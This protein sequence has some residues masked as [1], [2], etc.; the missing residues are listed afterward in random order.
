LTTDTHVTS[1]TE[2]GGKEEKTARVERGQR[3]EKKN[4]R[5][6]RQ[7]QA[8]QVQVKVLALSRQ[9]AP[10]MQGLEAQGLLQTLSVGL[11]LG[12]THKNEPTES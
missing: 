5:Q 8:Y 4:N 11:P 2:Q 10:F 6:Q 3:N 1:Q 9:V 7:T 12:Q